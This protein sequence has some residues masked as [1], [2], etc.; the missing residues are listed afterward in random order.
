MRESFQSVE[1]K[2]E[3]IKPPTAEGTEG[4]AEFIHAR[5]V[6]TRLRQFEGQIL[7]GNEAG[8]QVEVLAKEISAMV[9]DQ[10]LT[11]AEQSK[12]GILD[13]LKMVA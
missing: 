13:P 8:A 2:A 11:L 3:K 6:L 9:A 4:S 10:K 7:V 5:E 12:L 1:N